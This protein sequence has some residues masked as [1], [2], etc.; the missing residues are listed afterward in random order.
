MPLSKGGLSRRRIFSS[1]RQGLIY[2]LGSEP[3][4]FGGVDPATSTITNGDQPRL[5]ARGQVVAR[6][7]IRGR[8]HRREP[9][10]PR[11]QALAERLGQRRR[12]V[13]E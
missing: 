6:I 9:V 13:I 11:P 1:W 10:M 5:S 7:A 3:I 4:D 12:R 2:T 8:H